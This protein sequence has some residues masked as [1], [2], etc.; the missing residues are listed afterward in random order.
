M[1]PLVNDFAWKASADIG[2]MM[3]KG[4]N[5]AMGVFVWSTN[6]FI[7]EITGGFPVQSLALNDSDIIV[8]DD[9]R[10]S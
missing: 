9:V 8:L 2:V 5:S 7:N 3:L 1:S 4:K 10:T 6:S